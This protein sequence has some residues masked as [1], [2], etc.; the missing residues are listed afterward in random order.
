VLPSFRLLRPVPNLTIHATSQQSFLLDV[1]SLKLLSDG[2]LRFQYTAVYDCQAT[3][4]YGTFQ[5]RHNAS[6]T[7]GPTT[8]TPNLPPPPPAT[9]GVLSC[10][11]ATGVTTQSHT[12][13]QRAIAVPIRKHK[14]GFAGR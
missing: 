11:L 8:G 12:S 6:A 13:V 5:T 3:G 14:V 9:H 7:V 2:P 4:S 1:L 10:V